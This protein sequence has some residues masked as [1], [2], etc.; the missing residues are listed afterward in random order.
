MSQV[1]HSSSK[2][3]FLTYPLL[4]IIIATYVSFVFYINWSDW[5]PSWSDEF[6]YY[7]NGLR[8]YLNN[9][10]TSP[11]SRH[12]GSLL[13]ASDAHGFI[14]PLIDGVF[15][16]IV[17]WHSFNFIILNVLFLI[18]G[19][20]FLYTSLKNNAQFIVACILVLLYPTVLLYTF[21]FMQE[22]LQ[23]AF[24]LIIAAQLYSRRDK[25]QTLTTLA[26]LLFTILLAGICRPLWFFWVAGIIPMGKDRRTRILLSLVALGYIALSFL[27][28]MFFL[29]TVTDGYFYELM[30]L[31]KEHQYR[32]FI[33]DFY[34]HFI[35]NVTMFLSY[36]EPPREIYFYLK[37]V[38]LLNYFVLIYM[39]MEKKDKYYF[40][41]FCIYTINLLLLLCLYD[42]FDWREVRALAGLY[43][44]M[45]PILVTSRYVIICILTALLFFPASWSSTQ[46]R[47]DRKII[48][49]QTYKKL[50]DSYSHIA[51]LVEP[52]SYIYVDYLAK[53]ES[54]DLLALPLVTQQK[55]NI[56]YLVY[57]EREDSQRGNGY[58]YRYVMTR[59]DAKPPEDCKCRLL[60]QDKFYK[61]YANG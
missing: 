26:P 24:A 14:Y 13:F 18:I 28:T 21:A 58:L 15:A 32:F 52:D 25:P 29:E 48:N 3:K 9:S 38:L 2:M 8:F 17:G 31:L 23:T 27:Y 7:L 4:G 34:I 37:Y 12:G 35:Q 41:L 20:S 6:N 61:L 60:Y 45:I 51:Q 50:L 33:N 56:N 47:V 1:G 57:G 10:F 54:F 16:K 39:M 44:L 46:Y 5:Y 43:F 19:L 42:T 53:D 49:Q 36:S 30:Q 40:S 55:R 22:S 11:V 59:A